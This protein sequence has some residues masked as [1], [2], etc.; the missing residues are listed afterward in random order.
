MKITK[1]CSC[2]HIPFEVKTATKY[3][4]I[5]C[6]DCAKKIK[7]EVHKRRM[8]EFPLSFW[9]WNIATPKEV[10]DIVDSIQMELEK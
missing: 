6:N 4:R 8:K 1:Q 7:R 5:F 10:D 2:C 9:N 3:E